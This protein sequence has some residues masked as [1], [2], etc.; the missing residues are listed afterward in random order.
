MD[1][2]PWNSPLFL[3]NAERDGWNVAPSHLSDSLIEA[4]AG[5]GA[6]YLAIVTDAGLRESSRRL[7][8]AYP[9]REFALG[10]SGRWRL[11]LSRLGP[12]RRG[13]SAVEA[14]G[15]HLSR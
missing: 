4:L 5:E 11:I 10:D 9:T 3:Y 1:G 6:R 2:L 15:A 12:A 13:D 8:A 7:L 14:G